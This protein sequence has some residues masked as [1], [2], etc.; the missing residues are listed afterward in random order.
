EYGIAE[1]DTG[2]V[3]RVSVRQRVA[4][5]AS[6]AIEQGVDAV[7]RLR[8]YELRVFVRAARTWVATGV[9]SPDLI[10]LGGSF[11]RAMIG[12]PSMADGALRAS[13][14]RRWVEITGLERPELAVTIDEHRA[15]YRYLLRHPALPQGADVPVGAL[16]AFEDQFRLRKLDEL[17]RI[18]PSYP[19]SLAR[20]V[21]HH[22]LGKDPLALADFQ[23]YLETA[24]ERPYALRARNY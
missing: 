9:A 16:A 23:R 3:D 1:A 10:E 6:R 17:A 11:V 12:R 13:F 5:A 21:L 2:G 19:A 20:G 14:K 8:A 4:Q 18:D 24:P 7:L 22:R 15:L